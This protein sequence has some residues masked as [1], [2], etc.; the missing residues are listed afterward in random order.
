MN[1]HDL[2]LTNQRCGNVS[3]CW[4]GRCACGQWAAGP[5]FMPETVQAY[6]ADHVH[7][8]RLEKDAA[9]ARRIADE[10]AR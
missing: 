6:W 5:H 8:D 1:D 9:L 10:A 4:Y 3:T 2:Q 7:L